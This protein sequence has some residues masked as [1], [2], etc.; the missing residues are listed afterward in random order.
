MQNHTQMISKSSYLVLDHGITDLIN[1]S[2]DFLIQTL[3]TQAC[4]T[5]ALQT[6]WVFHCKFSVPQV[7]LAGTAV[8]PPT[9]DLSVPILIHSL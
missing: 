7:S 3:Q 1:M 4:Q 9:T 5:Q 2:T 8:S 6:G